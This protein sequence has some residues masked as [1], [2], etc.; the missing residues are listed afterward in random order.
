[1]DVKSRMKEEERKRRVRRIGGETKRD[2][3]GCWNGKG[4]VNF[5]ISLYEEV[6]LR[7]TELVRRVWGTIEARSWQVRGLCVGPVEREER[8]GRSV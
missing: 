4:L 8:G 6:Q 2:E 1:M 5:E 7:Y 3:V